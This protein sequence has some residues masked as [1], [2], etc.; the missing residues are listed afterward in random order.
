MQDLAHARFDH[1][2]KREHLVKVAGEIWQARSFND[3][4]IEA[5]TPV[6]I[7]EIDGTTVVVYPKEP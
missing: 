4:P 2:V 6:E 1:R 5:G 3:E 7:Y